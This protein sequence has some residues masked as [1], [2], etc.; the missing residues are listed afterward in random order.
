MDRFASL[1][2]LAG[3]PIGFLLVYFW[4]R[5]RG[6]V[7]SLRALFPSVA[8]RPLALGGLLAGGLM[9]LDALISW[10]QRQVGLPHSDYTFIRELIGTTWW[11]MGLGLIV[12]VLLGPF[13][14]E[15]FFRG[16]IYAVQISQGSSL[17]GLS[18]HFCCLSHSTSSDVVHLHHWAGAGIRLPPNGKSDRQCHCPS[19]E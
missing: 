14:E 7:K 2:V 5:R 3:I 10:L 8:W 4:H 18:E 16:Y 13:A 12:V 6:D 1:F 9:S 15:L 17:S 11:S 19:G